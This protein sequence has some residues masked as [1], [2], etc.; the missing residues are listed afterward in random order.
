MSAKFYICRHCGN[1][2]EKIEDKKVPVV[3]C[4]EKMEALIPNTVDASGEKHLP[5]VQVEGSKVTVSVGS[6]S[7]PMTEEHLIQWVH[8]VTDKG[9]QRKFLNPEDKPVVTFELSGEK[10]LEVYAWCNLHGL[11]MTE[12]K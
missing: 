11:W 3:C 5:V 1:I 8:L 6:V 4:G 7:H 9:S 12:V 2:I 10:P